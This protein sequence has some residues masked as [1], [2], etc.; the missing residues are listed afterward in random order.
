MYYPSRIRQLIDSDS[1]NLQAIKEVVDYYHALYEILSEQA[2]RQVHTP[3]TDSHTIASLF[4]ILRHCNKG[5]RPVYS[6]EHPDADYMRVTVS[7]DRLSLTDGQTA[8]LFT[9]QTVNIRFLLC[10][11]IVREMGEVTN[12]RACGITAVRRD[13]MTEVVITMPW[14]YRTFLEDK[15]PSRQQTTITI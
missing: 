12:L 9:P 3:R 6:L 15:Q 13:N 1:Q 2:M 4:D 14:R 8:A 11:Q 5:V 7:M 10:R